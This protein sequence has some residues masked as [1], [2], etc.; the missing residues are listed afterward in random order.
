[1]AIIRSG[2][3]LQP[4]IV[5]VLQPLTSQLCLVEISWLSVQPMHVVVYLTSWWLMFLTC[6]AAA[7]I[8][9]SDHSSLSAVISKAQAVPNL[10]ISRKVFLK[11]QV[12]WNT[13]C[14]HCRV[15]P[16]V[17]FGLL[18]ILLRFWISICCWWLEVLFQP[19]S[20]VCATRIRLGLIITAGMLLASSRRLIFGGPVIALWLTGKS[21][22]TVKWQLMKP[23][24]IPSHFSA[25]NRDVLMNAQSPHKWWSTLS[26]LFSFWVC[27]CHRLLV[28]VGDWCAS[29]L[30]WLI[31]SQIILMAS[32]QWSL[33]ICRSLA[34]HLRDPPPL[35]AGRVRSGVSC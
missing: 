17:T 7:P 6:K 22:S 9:N 8:G 24:Q 12:N 21:L 30:A 29:R 23:T 34:V 19:R 14:V 33:L 10:R 11:H 2:L 32:S 25:R 15:Y 18:T 31:C 16:G 20:S 5:M 35:P 27:H 1:M 3:V 13:V 28:E 4:R 26:L